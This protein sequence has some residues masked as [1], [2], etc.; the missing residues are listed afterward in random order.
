M[1]RFGIFDPMPEIPDRPRRDVIVPCSGD[2]HRV[3]LAGGVRFFASAR[4]PR[5][6]SPVDPLRWRRVV[7]WGRGLL[8]PVSAHG[9]DRIL[10]ASALAYLVAIGL[11]AALLWGL[12]DLWWPATI[13]LFGPRWVL[14]LPLAVLVPW[15]VAKDRA[16]LL[17]L[18]LAVAIGVGPLVGVR[19]GWRALL[20]EGSGERFRIGSFNAAGGDRGT[21]LAALLA[22][23][24]ADVVVFQE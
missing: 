4:C 22:E 7:A 3:R 21:P 16:L 5:C 14:L 15:A 20:P 13:L 11:A 19:S 1:G 12:S 2:A 6:R 8:R 17:P 24:D 10:H 9:A 18:G 23:L